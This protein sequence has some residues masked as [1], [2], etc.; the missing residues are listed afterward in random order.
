MLCP[1][2]KI[3]DRKTISNSLIPK[4]YNETKDIVT[5]QLR[6]VDVVSLTADGWTSTNNQSFIAV[7][8]H[9]IDM[10][11]GKYVLN[12]YLLGCV[13][14]DE[15]HTALNLAEELR[16]LANEYSLQNK[17][18]CIVTDNAANI[19]AAIRQTGWRH[20][21][22]FAHSLNLVVQSAIEEIKGQVLQVKAIV[23]FFNSSSSAAAK[24]KLMQLQMGLPE[25]K[26]KQD[27]VTRW[28]S[29]YDMISRILVI[30]D[31]AVSCLAIDQPRLNTL[32]PADWEILDQ[33]QEILK[34]FYEI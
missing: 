16:K 20:F 4:M 11:Q 18:S 7:T 31:A 22:C 33:A 17:I 25:L 5:C 21:P 6:N 13:P 26:L 1:N 24:L 34:I 8:C 19:T 14:F 9:F 23:Q 30:K 28:N 27:V 3:P 29:T 15:R 10:N 2:Y 12:S 32:S